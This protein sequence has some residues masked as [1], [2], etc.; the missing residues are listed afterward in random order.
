MKYYEII[1]VYVSV[2]EGEINGFH[3]RSIT[4]WEDWVLVLAP[5]K[6]LSEMNSIVSS[7]TLET[8]SILKTFRCLKQFLKCNKKEGSIYYIGIN[9]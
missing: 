4:S 8:P 1:S 7:F 3:V 9:S 5:S 6:V 2:K